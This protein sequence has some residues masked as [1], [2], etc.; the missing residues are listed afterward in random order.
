MNVAPSASIAA[1]QRPGFQLVLYCNVSSLNGEKGLVDQL[2]HFAW[3]ELMT[4]DVAAAAAFYG[5][6]VGWDVKD[7]STPELAYTVV[8]AGDAPVGGL[9]DLPEEGR[10]LGATPRWVGYV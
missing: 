1:A 8:A 2:G 5:T 3:Y 7:A 4:T 10:R 6:V 9:M